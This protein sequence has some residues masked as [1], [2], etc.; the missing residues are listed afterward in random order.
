MRKEIQLFIH[1]KASQINYYISRVRFHKFLLLH[2]FHIILINVLR[3]HVA[4]VV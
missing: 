4:D 2:F 3:L 1:I